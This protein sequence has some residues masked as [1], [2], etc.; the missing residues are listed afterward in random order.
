MPA[1]SMR[2]WALVMGA[3]AAALLTAEAARAQTSETATVETLVVTAQR[4]EESAN[5]VGMGI[6]A[7]RGEVLEQLHV[8][9]PRDLS[10]FAPSFSVSQSYQG[11]PTYTLRGI[12]FNTINLSATSTVGTYVDEVA[13][14]YPF[15]LTG[16][17]F[18]L[19]R[20][21]VLKGPQGTLYGRNTTAGLINFVTNKPTEAFSAALGG[22]VG[23]YETLNFEGHVNGQIAPGLAGRLAFRMENSDKGWQISNSRG[24]S[25]GE[26][27]RWAVRGALA[28]NPTD[29]LSVDA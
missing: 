25:Q 11:V 1:D 5:A 29:R 18:D 17:I 27:D 20:V 2:R 13:Y 4:R 16:P 23:N 8:T 12:G 9:G 21:E 7:V 19:E 10:A 22:E 14:A 26:V 28:F 6:Q 15:L 3:S 24:E